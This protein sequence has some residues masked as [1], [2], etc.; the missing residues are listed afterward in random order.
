[1]TLEN[2]FNKYP[3]IFNQ[4]Y[5]YKIN[6]YSIPNTWI[7]LVDNLCETIQQYI[8]HNDVHQVECTT[9]KEKFGSLRFY[10]TG[11]DDYVSGMVWFAE[12]LSIKL[13]IECKS[14]KNVQSTDG[15]ISYLCEDCYNKK[16]NK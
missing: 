10:Y 1:M 16:Q 12:N 15:W 13:C 7:E 14:T 5:K 6:W 3:K 2:L 9:L 8:D 11:G 4:N